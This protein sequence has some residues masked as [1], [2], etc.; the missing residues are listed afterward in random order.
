[1]KASF[2][3]DLS[4]LIF[5]GLNSEV[6]FQQGYIICCYSVNVLCFKCLS[7]TCE[8]TLFDGPPLFQTSLESDQF[9]YSTS[10][11]LLD[12]FFPVTSPLFKEVSLITDNYC[13]SP[14][15]DSPLMSSLLPVM[16]LLCLAL[17]LTLKCK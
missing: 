10:A 17:G 12:H 9:N 2:G 16:R 3:I 15:C 6:V 1:M 5:E 14:L 13:C 7:V 11:P 8:T 4:G